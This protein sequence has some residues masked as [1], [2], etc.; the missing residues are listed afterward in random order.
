M[1]S[2]ADLALAKNDPWLVQ[3]NTLISRLSTFTGTFEG[4][5]RTSTTS[6]AP[7][8]GSKSWTLDQSTLWSVGAVLL[9]YSAADPSKFML[10]AATV[11]S[12]TDLT[13]SVTIANGSGAVTDWVIQAPVAGLVGLAVD[14]NGD[15]AAGA[16]SVSA[17][18]ADADLAA[19]GNRAF[20]DLASGVARVGGTK[21]NGSNIAVAL[22]NGSAALI[23]GDSGDGET[24]KTINGGTR[25]AAGVVALASDLGSQSSTVTIAWDGRLYQYLVLGADLDIDFSAIEAGY[26][27]A[28]TIAIEQA[29]G[30]YTPTFKLAGAETYVKWLTAEPAWTGLAAGVVVV[31]RAEIDHDG[32]LYLRAESDVRA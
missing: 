23:E 12:G 11:S 18:A 15:V 9:A 27:G 5:A 3:W 29:A 22:C 26:W 8:T 19:S 1:T 13:L 32:Y 30:A 25:Y 6:I 14:S 24:K 21:G 10:G 4:L 31:V 17:K 20:L 28:K 7:A 16:G 2:F